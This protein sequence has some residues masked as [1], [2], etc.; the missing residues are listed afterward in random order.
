M[1]NY[2]YTECGL[3]NVWLVN[4]FVKEK[5]AYGIGMSIHDVDGLHRAIGNMLTNKIKLTGAEIRFLR[6][7]M[8]LS[9]RGLGDLL[10]V[11]EQTV[12]LWER[13]G[14]IPKTAD[15]MLRLIYKEHADG[16]PPVISAFIQKL[17][18]TDDTDYRKIVATETSNHW[19]A[20]L[21]A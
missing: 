12:L 13:N 6:K 19:A 18:D 11:Q 21:A 20:H 17:N 10:G 14:K 15:R 2:H 1:K 5:T 4:G 8:R 3:P 9:Q 7:E 16:K